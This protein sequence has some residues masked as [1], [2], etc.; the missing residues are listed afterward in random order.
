ML[1]EQKGEIDNP[2]IWPVLSIL[3]ASPDSWKVHHLM[4]ELQ[5]TTIIDPLDEDVQLDLFKRNFLIMNALYQLQEMLYP[6]QWL[7]VE[8]MNIRL[9]FRSTKLGLRK[10][11]IDVQD[12]LREYYLNWRNYNAQEE[13]V[14]EMLRSFWKRYRRY[15]GH[16]T[17]TTIERSNALAALGLPSDA[18]EKDIRQ[19]WRKMA[20]K[21]HPDR[22]EG[23]ANV[24]RT[25][26]EAWQSLRL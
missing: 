22:P 23:D 13:D 12:P 20:L 17:D 9:M 24:F 3:E 11:E 7:Q 5:K 26:C 4:A 21:W 6:R 2:L 25:M 8:S 14:K 1:A 10:Q 18:S 16:S 15:I 19:Q